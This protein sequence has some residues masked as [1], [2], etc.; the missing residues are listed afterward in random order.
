MQFRLVFYYL[1]PLSPKYLHQHS[2]LEHPQHILCNVRDQVSHPLETSGK[3][4]VLFILI[5]M[6]LDGRCIQSVIS[7]VSRT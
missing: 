1:L 7:S 4:T 3:I 2:I 5:F 6:L